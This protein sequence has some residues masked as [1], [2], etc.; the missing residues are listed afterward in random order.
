M[1]RE[2][3]AGLRTPYSARLQTAKQTLPTSKNSIDFTYSDFPCHLIVNRD[4]LALNLTF[5]EKKNAQK[6]DNYC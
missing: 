1:Y 3:L 6:I 2:R 5:M 4:K